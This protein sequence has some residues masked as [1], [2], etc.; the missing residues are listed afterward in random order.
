[1]SRSIDPNVPARASRHGRVAGARRWPRAA[2]GAVVVAVLAGGVFM[3]VNAA[4]GTPPGHYARAAAGSATAARTPSPRPRPAAALPVGTIGGYAVADRSLLLVDQSRLRAAGRR[5]LPTLVRYPV[6]PARAGAAGSLARGLFPL[7]VFAPGY[8]QCEGSY[9]SLLRAWASAGY[10]VAA[11]TFP[12]TSCHASSPDEADLVNQPGDMAYVISRLLVIS[13]RKH[14][15][16]SG[17]VA[18]ADIAVAGH[19]DGGDTVAAIAANTCCLDHK[20]AAAVVLAGAEWPPMGGSYFPKGTP[21]ILFVQ[22]DAD[23]INLPADSLMMY[24]ADTTGPRFYLDLFGAG[25]L[26]P[27]E[28]RGLPEAVVARVTTDFLDRYVARQLPAGA[29]M[30]R[31]GDAAGLADLVRGGHMP[32]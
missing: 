29:A 28:G 11:V 19:S 24:R 26:S 18:P 2:V 1:M 21:P 4:T 7:V 3:A 22:G 15:V 17:L 23:N 14:G 27:Y 5:V 10:V 25:H 8:L 9:R 16:L 12:R 13:G 20:V 6:I 32:P 30:R 31:A